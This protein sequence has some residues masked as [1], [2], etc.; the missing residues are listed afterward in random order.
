MPNVVLEAMA[1]GLPIIATDIGGCREL[2]KGWAEEW[3]V[4]PGD[5]D[6]LRSAMQLAIERRHRLSEIGSRARAVVESKYAIERIA[7]EYL[8]DCEELLRRRHREQA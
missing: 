4:P 6:S 8:N 7:G 1:S 2:L 5:V 3:L